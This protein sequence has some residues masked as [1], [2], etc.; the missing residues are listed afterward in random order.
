MGF[1]AAMIMFLTFV[2]F[3]CTVA[4]GYFANPKAR[5]HP[6]EDGM[7]LAP[8]C[9]LLAAHV[10]TVSF[11]LYGLNTADKYWEIKRAELEAQAEKTQEQ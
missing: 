6:E 5:Q 1:Q 10:L 4:I 7:V 8:L 2:V 3:M 9:I 11:A